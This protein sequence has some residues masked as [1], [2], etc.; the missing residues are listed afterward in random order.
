MSQSPIPKAVRK[1]L[2]S[3]LFT[4]SLTTPLLLVAGPQVQQLKG[5]VTP[6]IALAPLSRSVPPNTQFTL[7]IGLPVQHRDLLLNLASSVSDPNSD[8]YRNYLTAEEFAD[9]FGANPADY[10]AVVDWA[11]ANNLT[12]TAHRNRFVVTVTGSAADI[13][14]ALNLHLNYRLRSDGTEFFAPDA[15]PSIDLGVPVE[16]ISGLENF[17][18]P[19]RAGGSGK[20]GNYQGADFRNAYAPNMTLTGSGQKIGIFM[21]DGF[22]QS[23]INGYAS[24]TNQSFLSVQV[25][26]QGTALT[27]GDEGT[28]DIEASLSVA[29]AAQVITFVGS[30]NRTAILTNMTDRT[31]VKQ[32]TS[33]WFWYNGSTTDTNLILQ[34]KIQGQTFFQASGDGGAYQKG[35][36][37]NYISGSLDCRQFPGITLVGG[38][39]LNMSSNGAA[40]GTL[41]T[42][43]PSSSGGIESSVSLPSFQSGLNGINGA[44]KTNRNVPDVSAQAQDIIIYY[45][46]GPITVGG[47]SLA[48]PL[49][50]GYMALV[51]QLAAG[52]GVN[53]PG[54]INPQL[55]ALAG[56]SNY[57][58]NFHDVV[59]GCTPNGLSGSNAN[60][61]C[62]GTGYD[63]AT[64]LGTPQHTLIYTLSGVQAYPLF[65]QGPLTTTNNLTTFKWANAKAG[66]VPPGPGQ[67]AWADRTPTGTEIK[68]G[69]T[70]ILS[71]PLGQVANLAA[72]KYAEVGVYNAPSNHDMVVT[73]IVG[74]VS[75]PFSSSA[76]LP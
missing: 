36:W 29:P 2:A 28:L 57:A 71:G 76:T 19:T 25:V 66:S 16:H 65:C 53:S 24:Q 49:W 64:G 47:T 9:Q 40:Y 38:S 50:A 67:C 23:D 20:N 45:K 27:P 69:N 3:A 12:V 46:G 73:Q 17:I 11:K 72:G 33:S 68:S 14:S 39:V 21:L 55:Y 58:K 6:E 60:K 1:V 26:P 56:T 44:S 51:N 15:D 31:D 62:A 18:P 59:S 10:Q 61:Y 34:M 35:V 22:A 74:Q 13:E 32:F 37:P 43:W 30:S 63:L 5:Y 75:P 7:S 42:A 4:L 70:N 8:S 54:F 41:E 48:T 52:G